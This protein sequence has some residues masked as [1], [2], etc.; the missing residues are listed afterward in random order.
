[1]GDEQLI[2][3]QH[4][5]GDVLMKNGKMQ[6]A[7]IAYERVVKLGR[8]GRKWFTERSVPNFRRAYARLGAVY[9]RTGASEKAL[10]TF[11]MAIAGGFGSTAIRCRLAR[12]YLNQRS[13]GDAVAEVWEGTKALPRA[14]RQSALRIAI[15]GG[16]GR[17]AIHCRLAC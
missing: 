1:A 17:T 14:V 9:D 5:L 15:A 3:A 13:W 7:M 12:I 4:A 10:S 6:E 16:F 11:R 2:D 8:M